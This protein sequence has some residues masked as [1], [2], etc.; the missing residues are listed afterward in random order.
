VQSTLAE[1]SQL[2]DFTGDGSQVSPASQ[3]KR[4]LLRRFAP[5]PHRVCIARED[6]P[7][8]SPVRFG[9]CEACVIA[10]EREVTSV[11]I[12]HFINCLSP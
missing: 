8:T 6:L 4:P 3:A 9:R 2:S 1:L 5:L 10:R 12:D 7:T 11:D